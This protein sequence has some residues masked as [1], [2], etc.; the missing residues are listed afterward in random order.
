MKM[1]CGKW[2]TT[3][4]LKVQAT[5]DHR[6]YVKQRKA[7]KSNSCG[8]FTGDKQ[9]RYMEPEVRTTENNQYRIKHYC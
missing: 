3:I 6:W 8:W 2:S 9:R 4:L 1:M 7:N 5:A